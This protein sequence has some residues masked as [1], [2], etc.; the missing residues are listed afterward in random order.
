MK[1]KQIPIII[2]GALLG[3]TG[4]A[5]MT[6]TQQALLNGGGAG[7]IVGVGSYFLLRAAG[8]NNNTAATISPIFATFVAGGVGYYTYHEATLAQQRASVARAK[9]YYATLD[10][11]QQAHMKK[12]AVKT[13]AGSKTK[14][15]PVG[16]VDTKTWKA[17]PSFTD[18]KSQPS[19]FQVIKTPNNDS[20]TFLN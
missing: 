11:S 7:S 10:P 2:I 5:N 13:L 18:M 3:T 19:N 9:K 6:P 1:N 17:D 8:V 12:I 14:G 16:F 15:V 4:C 20:A